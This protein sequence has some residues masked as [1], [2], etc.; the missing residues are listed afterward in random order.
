MRTNGESSVK[1]KLAKRD[2]F[3]SEDFIRRNS[4]L[5]TLVVESPQHHATILLRL[6]QIGKRR[7]RFFRCGTNAFVLN[8]KQNPFRSISCSHCYTDEP[9]GGLGAA[10]FEGLRTGHRRG[11]MHNSCA[12]RPDAG[13]KQSRNGKRGSRPNFPRVSNDR[14]FEA[15][16]GRTARHCG[17]DPDCFWHTRWS[18]PVQHRRGKPNAA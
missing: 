15:V 6:F 13:K 2:R 5:F 9:Q 12:C 7:F 1:S 14:S 18:L 4:S 11:Q 3:H 16:V 8:S 17:A 10:D